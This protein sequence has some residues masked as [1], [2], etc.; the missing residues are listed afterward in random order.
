MCK[1]DDA[2]RDYARISREFVRAVRARRSQAGLSRRLGY[3]SNVVCDWEAGRRFPTAST[4]L[5]V[6]ERTGIDVRSAIEKFTR[7]SDGWP[8]AVAPA[9]PRGVVLLLNDLR[10]NASIVELAAATE[11]SRFAI[12]RWL[13][14]H[15]EPR[16]PDFLKFVE[17]TSLRLLDFLATL[18]DVGQMPSLRVEWSQLELA[19]DLAYTAPWSHAVLRVLELEEYRRSPHH[20]AGFVAERLGISRDEEERCLKLLV[21]AK[22]VYLENGC[23]RI[24]ETRTVD[25]RRDPVRS[26]QLRAFWSHVAAERL[27][28]GADGE[29]AFNLFGVSSADLERLRNLQR[30][31]FL[32]LRSIVA[33][34]TRVEHVVLT[35]I[36]LVPLT[37]PNAGRP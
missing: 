22:H 29:F 1:T 10:G 25:T 36:Q 8:R 16:L 18:V 15:T 20:V 33:R 7:P 19:R 26:R 24:D 32:E 14:G 6:A 23:F 4:A 34:S 17:K 35:N 27:T 5:R 12:S 21:Q 9:S 13:K 31:Y 30:D 37:S 2:V 11:S 28:A 3:R